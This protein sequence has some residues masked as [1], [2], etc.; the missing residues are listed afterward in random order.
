M[1]IQRHAS[2]SAAPCKTG[3]VQSS[4]DPEESRLSCNDR[5]TAR[6]YECQENNLY[7]TVSATSFKFASTHPARL[8]KRKS[9]L[10]WSKLP[11]ASIR[12]HRAICPHWSA[13]TKSWTKVRDGHRN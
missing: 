11:A 8:S 6:N 10:S 9:R 2:P 1:G 12:S 5:Q 4:N 3:S 13:R 7:G